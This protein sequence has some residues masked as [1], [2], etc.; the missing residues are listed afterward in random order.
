MTKTRQQVGPFTSGASGWD[1]PPLI[2]RPFGSWRPLQLTAEALAPKSWQ[3][4]PAPKTEARKGNP[5]AG[6]HLND[7]PWRE[8]AAWIALQG[9]GGCE[10]KENELWGAREK[11]MGQEEWIMPRWGGSHAGTWWG[12]PRGF[13]RASIL[14][15]LG[16]GKAVLQKS[17]L[18]SFLCLCFQEPKRSSSCF[19]FFLL[20]S[21][22]PAKS[23]FLWQN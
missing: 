19:C 22:L 5:R 16:P 13:R 17:L 11:T 21:S 10:G 7:R 12:A 20:P 23:L 2:S 1:P 3:P 8:G 18:F 4:P 15:A 14:G 6:G 9:K